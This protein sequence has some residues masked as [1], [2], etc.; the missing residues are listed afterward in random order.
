ML[1]FC[2]LR[3]I[4]KRPARGPAHVEAS[5]LDAGGSFSRSPGSLAGTDATTRF[6]LLLWD[7]STQL[8]FGVFS[9]IA[10]VGAAGVIVERRRRKRVVASVPA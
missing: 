2:A 4:L 6:R 1:H 10:L 7:W 3:A 8:G 5:R 9:L